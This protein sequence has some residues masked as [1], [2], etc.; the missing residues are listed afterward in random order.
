MY[1]YVYSLPCQDF[2]IFSCGN[3]YAIMYNCLKIYI[4]IA[5]VFL[6]RLLQMTVTSVFNEHEQ[7]FSIGYSSVWLWFIAKNA[8]LDF[9]EKRC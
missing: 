3:C 6:E 4:E 8:S 7:Q 1:V 2:C 5:V 9:R